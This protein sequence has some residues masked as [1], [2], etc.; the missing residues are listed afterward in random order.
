MM[1]V[2]E[3]AMQGI[4]DEMDYY[5]NMAHNPAVDD[6]QEGNMWWQEDASEVEFLNERH[7]AKKA[8]GRRLN[9][10]RGGGL[11]GIVTASQHR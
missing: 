11:L 8:A 7:G 2:E 6:A 3:E 9:F 10:Y 1:E 4:E 5:V